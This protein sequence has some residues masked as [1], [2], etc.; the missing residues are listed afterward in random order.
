M[1]VQKIRS[2]VRCKTWEIG[3]TASLLFCGVV[4]FN[5]EWGNSLVF[6]SQYIGHWLLI[7]LY[8]VIENG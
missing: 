3:I 5:N 7:I 6:K 8:E 2:R 1:S 4:I